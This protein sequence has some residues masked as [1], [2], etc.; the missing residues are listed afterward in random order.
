MDRLKALAR[1]P[2]LLID[3]GETLLIFLVAF[4]AHISGDQQNYIVAAIIALVG[5]CKAFTTKPFPVTLVVDAARA[6]LVVMASF[7]VG[8]TADQIAITATMIGTVTTVIARAQITPRRDPIVAGSG[9][10]AGPVTAPRNEAGHA[11]LGTVGLVL[12]LLG[13]VL[14]VLVLLHLILLDVVVPI[15]VIVVGAL[16]LI[17]GSG[18]PVA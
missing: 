13:F 4:G 11:P 10:G 17:F 8:L 15:I 16:L 2:A 1:E 14:L 12:L 9:A 7:G 3:L 6:V 18:R 5:L